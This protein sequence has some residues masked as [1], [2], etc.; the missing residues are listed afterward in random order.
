MGDFQVVDPKG[1]EYDLHSVYASYIGFLES[2]HV[3]WYDKTWGHLFSTFE[4]FLAFGWPVIVVTDAQTGKAHIVT[5]LTSIGAFLRMIKTRF[6]ETLPHLKDLSNMIPVITP[7]EIAKKY[8]LRHVSDHATYRKLHN[9]LPAAAL[10]AYKQRIRNGEPDAIKELWDRQDKSFLAIDFEWSE[11]NE[12]STLEWGYAAVRCGALKSLKVWPPVPDENYRKGHYVVQEYIDKVV[13]KHCPTYPWHYAFGESQ[14]IS[15]FKLPQV[16]QAVISSLASPDSE[17]LPNNLVLVAHGASNDLARLE[18]MKIKLPHNMLVIDTASF[19]RRLYNQGLRPPMIDPKT[20]AERQPSSTLSLGNLL[21]SFA[22][23]DSIVLPNIKFH[24]SGN[25]ALMSLFALQMLI[26]PKGVKVPTPRHP[27]ASRSNTNLR[28]S[29]VQVLTVP[30]TFYS[31]YATVVPTPNGSMLAPRSS[32]YDLSSEFGQMRLGGESP[33]RS[34]PR[35]PRP[36]LTPGGGSARNLR[37]LTDFRHG[38]E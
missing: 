5:R 11:R 25:D 2:N 31:G 12:K 4:E 27:A 1:W 3:P 22:M 13:N 9:T 29:T 24:N 35:S 16:V 20:N 30:Q 33:N 28:S 32:A 26:N 36:R 17:T 7:F 23:T 34:I 21:H 10:T 8:H 18:E 14:V 38:D 15:K 19:E 6:G 37:R